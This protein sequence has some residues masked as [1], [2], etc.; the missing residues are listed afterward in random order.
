MGGGGQELSL[1]R[2]MMPSA[3]TQCY[4]KVRVRELKSTA[5]SNYLPWRS[6]FS[7]RLASV[8]LVMKS[9]IQH[10]VLSTYLLSLCLVSLSAM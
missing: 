5:N 10:T 8:F 9:D 7:L 1:G 2:S 3:K 6:L 4:E